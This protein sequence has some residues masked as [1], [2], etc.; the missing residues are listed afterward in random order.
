MKS[1]HKGEMGDGGLLG[2]VSA[3]TN[4][5]LVDGLARWTIF[6]ELDDHNH[7]FDVK[8]PYC[9]HTIACKGSIFV[10]FYYYF[11]IIRQKLPRWSC[12]GNFPMSCNALERH[13]KRKITRSHF[14]IFLL[15]LFVIYSKE[16][17]QSCLY[18]KT[19]LI[20]R[21]QDSTNLFRAQRWPFHI[22]WTNLEKTLPPNKN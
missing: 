3:S 4:M 5:F 16:L 22:Y 15:A 20:F 13:W 8:Q 19:V 11:G 2:R 12:R 9:D 14:R 1:L 10:V 17:R 21:Q 18:F 6:A 7:D